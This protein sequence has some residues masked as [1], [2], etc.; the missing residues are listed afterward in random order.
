MIA[1]SAARARQ[2]DVLLEVDRALE[3]ACY[4]A[5]RG[6]TYGVADGRI[7]L[8][9]TVP[10]WYMKQTAQA[11]VASV[12]DS[13]P[14]DNQISVARPTLRNQQPIAPRPQLAL[15]TVPA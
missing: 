6:V 2:F 4:S 1:D 3:R 13:H 9:G 8:E 10:S 14:I 11:I 7:L 5:L 15:A 12:C